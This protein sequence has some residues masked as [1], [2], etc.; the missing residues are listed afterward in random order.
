[1]GAE[2]RAA[3]RQRVSDREGHRKKDPFFRQVEGERM[4]DREER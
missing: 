2:E 1:M 3:L 4:V